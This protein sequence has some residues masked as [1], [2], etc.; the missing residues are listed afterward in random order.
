ME[1]LL[2]ED[3]VDA[4]VVVTRYF[5]GTLLGSGGLARA[6]GQ[7]AMTALRAAGFARMRPHSE[8]RVTIEYGRFGVV[9]QGLQH[10]G[11]SIGDKDFA[12]LVRFT[13]RVPVGEEA[14][15]ASMIA[16][17]TAGAGLT[18]VGQTVYLPE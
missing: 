16:D 15:L 14:A 18:E 17:L 11:L 9:E 7:A 13:V 2:R 8:V 1:L 10:A 5:G 3:L 6:Y 12:D 4:A